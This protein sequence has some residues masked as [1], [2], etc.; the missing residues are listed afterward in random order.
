MST[1]SRQRLE[2]IQA[3]FGVDNDWERAPGDPARTLRIDL[4][5]AGALLVSGADVTHSQFRK[6]P[7]DLQVVRAGDAEHRVHPVG[8]KCGDERLP[9]GHLSRGH[10]SPAFEESA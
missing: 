3:W 6:V 9:A 7:V 1:E 10:H 5:I 4:L 2:R 8:R